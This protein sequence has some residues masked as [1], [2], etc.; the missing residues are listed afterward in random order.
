MLHVGQAFEQ[1]LAALMDVE[2]RFDADSGIAQTVEDSRPAGHTV[3]V[4]G[5]QP[6]MEVAVLIG[7]GATATFVAEHIRARDEP[8]KQALLESVG[9]KM[10]PLSGRVRI[11]GPEAFREV[12]PTGIDGVPG[13]HGFDGLGMALGNPIALGMFVHNVNGAL[14]I[15]TGQQGDGKVAIT[16]VH[17]GKPFDADGFPEIIAKDVN[18]GAEV[19]EEL[20]GGKI[21]LAQVPGVVLPTGAMGEVGFVF[22][23]DK[24]VVIHAGGNETGV[25]FGVVLVGNNEFI[26]IPLVA[27][28]AGVGSGIDAG[29]PVGFGSTAAGG[30]VLVFAQGELGGFLDANNVI[31][32]AKIGIYVFLTLV[33]AEDN[34]G[35]IGKD[36]ETARGVELVG[37]LVEEALAEVF[38]VFEV[39]FA[40]FTEQEAFEAG[41]ALAII[42]ADLGE[43]PVG[44]AAA[45]R[46]AVADGFGAIRL[47]AE[48]RGGAG[49]KLAGLEDN[50]SLGDIEELV[51]GTALLEAKLQGLLE[52]GLGYRRQ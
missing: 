18:F 22:R 40:D 33:M 25:G 32:Q 16:I 7:N 42:G 14:M 37:Q 51:F 9:K 35:A 8:G 28:T 19:F 26:E 44:F 13:E 3:H 23:V 2:G 34:A 24:G 12:F 45:A 39:G 30:D 50:A 38:K 10:V 15:L 6:D 46:A 48:A 29:P 36:E 1:V 27:K 41:N 17:G 11:L 47:I 5:A 43:E 52:L 21:P 49:S 4:G 31:F 20:T